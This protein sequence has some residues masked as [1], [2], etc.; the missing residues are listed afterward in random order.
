MILS[1]VSFSLSAHFILYRPSPW[2]GLPLMY[3]R[4]PLAT[5]D[6]QYS[7]W[8]I[9]AEKENLL[10]DSTKHLGKALT[11]LVWVICS[12]WYKSLWQENIIWKF[13][14][15]LTCLLRSLGVVSDS[16]STWLNEGDGSP[17]KKVGGVIFWGEGG[18]RCWPGAAYRYSP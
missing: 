7:Q 5:S 15:L 3:Q 1:G 11:G 14:G 4:R 8:T 18:S 13:S 16:W 17:K 10:A 12:P 2:T 6:S 9:L